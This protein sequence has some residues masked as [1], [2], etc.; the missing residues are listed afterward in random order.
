M[1]NEEMREYNKTVGLIGI[2]SSIRAG[3]RSRH[4]IENYLN[5]SEAYMRRVLAAYKEKYGI[6]EV[7]D[8]YWITFEPTLQVYEMFEVAEEI[9]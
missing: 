8:N 4:E 6:G 5:I 1:N 3:C 7:L 9:F 2:I